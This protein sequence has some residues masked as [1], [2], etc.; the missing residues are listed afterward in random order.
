MFTQF[1]YYNLNSCDV[2]L[3]M[4]VEVEWEVFV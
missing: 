2:E 3:G 4:M 1:I